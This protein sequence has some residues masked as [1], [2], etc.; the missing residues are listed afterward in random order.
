M[1]TFAYRQPK[2]ANG[3]T[4][5][6]ADHPASQANKLE[7]LADAGID[8][9]DNISFVKVD[10]EQ[11]DLTIAFRQSQIDFNKSVFV[12]CLGVL[13]Y[14]TQNAIAKIFRFI[15]SLPKGIEF[16]FTA[17]EKRTGRWSAMVAEKVAQSGEPWI[18]HFD[19]TEMEKQLKES[20]FKEVIFLSPAEAKARYFTGV[21]V[22][23]P[24]LQRC[25]LIM[26]VV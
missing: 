2:W 19:F 5:V 16:V 11:D 22:Q 15:G 7:H 12:A 9:P 13:V 8:I 3:L 10:L 24:L 1:D 17:S 6:E 26:A 18:S 4:I 23:V 25:S 21:K 14:L 20:G